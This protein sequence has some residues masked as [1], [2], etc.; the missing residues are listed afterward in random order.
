MKWTQRKERK[1]QI[2]LQIQKNDVRCNDKNGKPTDSATEGLTGGNPAYNEITRDRNNYS[3]QD[4]SNNE[5][6]VKARKNDV[7]RYKYKLLK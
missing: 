5:M 4:L 7:A 2:Y 1:S 6:D 3:A